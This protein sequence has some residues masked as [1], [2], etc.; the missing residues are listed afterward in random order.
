MNGAYNNYFFVYLASNQ[1][2]VLGLDLFIILLK[3]LSL[4]I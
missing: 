3:V 1:G 2:S 4:K